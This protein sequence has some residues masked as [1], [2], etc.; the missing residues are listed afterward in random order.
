MKKL[1][2]TKAVDGLNQFEPTKL[3]KVKYVKHDHFTGRKLDLYTPACVGHTTFNFTNGANHPFL[4][5]QDFIVDSSRTSKGG[6]SV[7]PLEIIAFPFL[8][9]FTIM[10]QPEACLPKQ[11]FVVKLPKGI[12]KGYFSL[13]F[14]R[15]AVHWV[16]GQGNG[17]YDVLPVTIQFLNLVGT[18]PTVTYGQLFISNGVNNAYYIYM[19]GEFTSNF[20]FTH[21]LI[22]ATIPHRHF[23]PAIDYYSL[24]SYSYPF[25]IPAA[26][27][28]NYFLFGYT[29]PDLQDKGPIIK[30]T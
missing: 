3:K 7:N 8:K 27:N 6:E 28:P 4:G 30:I 24:L 19:N 26:Q 14:G 11:L 29:S 2:K 10:I 18:A 20:S 25:G 23:L 16:N 22:N 12:N 15:R 5:V 13:N 21:I 9:G 17:T 1:Q